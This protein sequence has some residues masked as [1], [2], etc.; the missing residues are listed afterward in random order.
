[1]VTLRE[2]F[3]EN[4]VNE[5]ECNCPDCVKQEILDEY[6]EMIL[7][8]EN[9]EELRELLNELYDEAREQMIEEAD[10]ILEL[11][12]VTP[13]TYNISIDSVV[14]SNPSEFLEI[15]NNLVKED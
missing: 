7:D 6:A 5:M 14:V 15:F 8:A 2:K 13:I 3:E 9:E 12:G 4:E 1:M 10:E 11:E